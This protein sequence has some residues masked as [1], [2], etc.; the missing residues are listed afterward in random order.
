MTRQ[1]GNTTPD[2]REYRARRTAKLFEPCRIGTLSL[3]NRVVMA[4]MTRT[5]SPGGIPGPGERG[6]L[7]APG[8]RWRRLDC[9]G[10]HMGGSGRC[11]RAGCAAPVW[12]RC[13]R[14]LEARRRRG[15]QRGSPILCQLWHVGQMKQP[16]IEGLYDAKSDNEV[17][18][19]GLGRPA[20][21][22]GLAR[23]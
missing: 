19:D 5:M 2:L 9:N 8:Q 21:L 15:P 14:R 22:A 20:G 18:P 1:V 10:R 6:L 7:P 12:K 13:S 17:E 16:I 3:R 4:P 11:E 23:K